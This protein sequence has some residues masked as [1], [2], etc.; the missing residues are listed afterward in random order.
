MAI[1]V[2]IE[3]YD[4]LEQIGVGGMA[5]VYRARKTSIDKT[6]AIKVLFPY[7]ATDESFIERFQREAKAA[8]SIQHENIVNVIDFG[9]SD[10]SFF[11]VMEYYDGCT[12]EKLMID[13]PG[14]PPEIALQILLEVAY[15]L[16]AAH[17][18]D[19]VHRDVKPA[20]IIFTSQGGIKIADFGLAR[21]SDSMT[22]TQEGKVMGTPAYMSPEQAAGRPVGTPSDIFSFGV[23]AYELLS[24]R[25]PF[26]GRTYSEV[27]EKIQ[28][29]SPAALT[30]AN[31][32]VAPDFEAIVRRALEKDERNR[33]AN[34]SELIADLEAAMEKHQIARDRRR[35]G[36][37]VKD[38]AAYDAA[39]AEK[40][41]AHCLSRGAF[42]MQKGNTHL[43]DAVLEYRRILHL[44]P[45]H[46]RARTML[47]ELRPPGEASSD[48]PPTLLID[49]RGPDGARPSGPAPTR[50]RVPRWTYALGASALAAAA[51]AALWMPAT[52][53]RNES[54]QTSAALVAGDT[55][56]QRA[57][58]RDSLGPPLP[59]TP[60]RTMSS[61]LSGMTK[62]EDVPP[63]TAGTKT[64]TEKTT[65]DKSSAKDEV[66]RKRAAPPPTRK[67][68]P[69]TPENST[70][71]PA[72]VVVPP[73]S[74]SVYYLG[75]VGELW[76]DGKLFAYQPPFDKANIAAGVHKIACRMSG[77][78]SR[79]ELTVT[80]ESGKET[81]IEYEIGGEPAVVVD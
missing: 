61:S 45:G 57:A 80:I 63:R 13:R 79:R 43:E 42:F 5:A 70:D 37:Y 50:R 30:M 71:A 29:F 39:F 69:V 51:I 24:G 34:A 36:V 26:D 73:G 60:P 7:L 20:N 6:V 64:G 40:T 18:L 74:L 65:K 78:E 44:D 15:G 53:K 54:V 66:A 49:A 33:Y 52:H 17:A 31:P 1:R 55:A 59:T 4:S 2:A 77:E 76:V 3:G 68:R 48:G 56:A 16:E 81:V 58:A 9:E 12:L 28:T 10:G 47:A 14:L 22:L 21:K 41:I 38:P 46:E 27:L 75:G 8:A 23:V 25:K 72:V 67:E 62:D 11:I 32:L 19:I 35:L